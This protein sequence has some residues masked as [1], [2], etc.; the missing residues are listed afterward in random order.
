MTINLSDETMLVESFVARMDHSA[1]IGE[2]A[3]A[4]F[5]EVM[6]SQSTCGL[7]AMLMDSL[8]LA[9]NDGAPAEILAAAVEHALVVTAAYGMALGALEAVEDSITLRFDQIPAE[10]LDWFGDDVEAVEVTVED[11]ESD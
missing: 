5:P 8:V 7:I 11:P 10:F 1:H 2:C 3:H 6:E 4:T 9:A